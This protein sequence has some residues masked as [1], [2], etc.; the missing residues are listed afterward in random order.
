M[1]GGPL[2]ARRRQAEALVHALANTLSIDGFT[3][4]AG[5]FNAWLGEREPAIRV[6]REAFPGAAPLRDGPTWRG[7]M[8]LHATLDYLFARGVRS[9]QVRRLPDRFG[10]DHY[11]LLAVVGGN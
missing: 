2:S 4:V 7:P 11:P 8:G 6:L 5:D 10:S 1:H 9:I 3:I